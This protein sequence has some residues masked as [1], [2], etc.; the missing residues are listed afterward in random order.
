MN[1]RYFILATL[2]II[3]LFSLFYLIGTTKIKIHFNNLEPLKHNLPVYYNGFKLGKSIKIYPNKDYT[4]TMVDIRIALRDLELPANITASI[5]RKDKK[6]YIEL[7]YP[8]APALAKV[9]NNDTIEG[10]LGSNFEHY[11]HLVV[12]LLQTTPY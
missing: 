10:T 3:I 8:K 6:D 1:K 2:A 9:K 11:L 5:R 4:S 7:N 12:F